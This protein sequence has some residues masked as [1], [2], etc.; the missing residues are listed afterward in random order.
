MSDLYERLELEK[1]ATA[2]EIKSSYRR[3]AKK[4]HP[5]INK[6]NP[7]AE[8]LFREITEAYD[9]LSDPE[10]R[11]AYD[12]TGEFSGNKSPD[13]RTIVLESL[14]DLFETT[15]QSPKVF[16]NDV[17]IF[18]KM[19]K[20]VDAHR[21][22]LRREIKDMEELKGGLEKLVERFKYEGEG[23]NPFAE[24]VLRHIG[25]LENGIAERTGA[26]H[27][28]DLCEDELELHESV[29]TL[30]ITIGTTSS[31]APGWEARP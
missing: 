12:E 25:N 8:E 21:R 2:A 30:S 28:A 14:L 11:T 6:D 4:C 7:E 17:D 5:D 19:R 31:T 29:V 10:T 22:G 3:L 18:K 20:D 24:K 13:I 27:V 1:G 15:L 26:I 16:R 9:I 23:K